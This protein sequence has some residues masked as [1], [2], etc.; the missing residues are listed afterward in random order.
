[1][2]IF[3]GR[4]PAVGP[5][6]A[7]TCALACWGVVGLGVF[8]MTHGQ[9]G[10]INMVLGVGLVALVTTALATHASITDWLDRRRGGYR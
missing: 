4:P 6:F 8:L 3:M 2:I 10:A 1:M 5:G 7:W 9:P